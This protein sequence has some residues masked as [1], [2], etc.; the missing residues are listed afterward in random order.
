MKHF[1]AYF[2][3]VF[4]CVSLHA[5][6]WDA[7]LDQ[8][9]QISEECIRLRQKSLSGEKVSGNALVPLLNQLATLRKS[10]QTA[11][12][13]MSVDQKRRFESI[14]S[15]Y[16]AAFGVRKPVEAVFYKEP[17]PILSQASM[18]PVPETDRPSPE[19][20]RKAFE[21]PVSPIRVSAILFAGI[22]DLNPG[23]LLAVSKGRWGGFLKGSSTV[24]AVRPSYS[25]YA[26]G[27]TDTGYIW[28][29]GKEAVK[30]FSIAAGG[31]FSPLSFLSVYAGAGYG[32]RRLFWEDAAGEWAAVR[33][34]SASGITVDAGVLLSWHHLSVMAGASAVGLKSL[35]AELGIGYRF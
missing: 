8:Y 12:G 9:E 31:T 30:R 15:R 7:A 34:R 21:V 17:D 19:P 11:G 2:V 23:L 24:T 35:S 13:N 33:D 18:P 5:Q 26:D 10:L 4:L 14:R 22:P 32:A 25:C 28:T 29:S 3:A 1:L 20:V 16:D 27:T 6:S